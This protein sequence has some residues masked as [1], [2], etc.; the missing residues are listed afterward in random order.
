MAFGEIF[1]A[2]ILDERGRQYN[3]QDWTNFNM[4]EFSSFLDSTSIFI[5][6]VFVEGITSLDFY[7]KENFIVHQSII[8]IVFRFFVVVIILL[9]EF[10]VIVSEESWNNAMDC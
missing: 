3:I 5:N 2:T 10:I 9:N 1:V 6:Y 8:P 4:I 7:S